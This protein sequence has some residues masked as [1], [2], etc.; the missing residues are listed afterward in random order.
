MLHIHVRVVEVYLDKAIYL[1]LKAHGKYGRHTNAVSIIS[2]DIANTH[3]YELEYFDFSS[4]E[5]LLLAVIW[6]QANCPQ[7]LVFILFETA[8]I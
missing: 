4:S 2:V 1:S 6:N 7:L 3:P 5:S 8:F